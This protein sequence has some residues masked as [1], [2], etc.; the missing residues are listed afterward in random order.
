MHALDLE[1]RQ[2]NMVGKLFRTVVAQNAR[3]EKKNGKRKKEKTYLEAI[4]VL[5]PTHQL[6]V[7]L[8]CQT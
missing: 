8:S 4:A 7:C 5:Y 2:R 1:K 6:C 3:R